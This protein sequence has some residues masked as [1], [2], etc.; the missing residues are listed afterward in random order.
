MKRIEK[1]RCSLQTKLGVLTFF[2][3]RSSERRSIA[4]S[5]DAKGVVSVYCPFFVKQ[6]VVLD[7]V[8][9]KLD[10]ILKRTK[11]ARINKDYLDS[12]KFAEGQEFLFLGKKYKIRIDRK[13]I[14]RVKL[15]FNGL[16][17]HVTVPASVEKSCEEEVLKK[18]FVAWYKA[19]AKE[20]LGGRIFNYS[21]ILG[22]YPE[23]IKI[24]TLKR[25]WGNCAYNA[26]TITLN[27]QIILSPIAV[28]DYVV[29][30]ELCH[31]IVPSHSKRFWQKVEKILPRYKREIKWLKDNHLDMVLP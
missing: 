29:V 5:V 20:I 21:R 17:W 26:K 19:Q 7:F 18:A 13:D 6:P 14:K 3:T 22:V 8:K 16:M 27:W 31:L 9:Q 10:W 4:I 30:H 24:R 28:V 12:K 1:Q 23:K 15:D 25:I 2:L 11:E